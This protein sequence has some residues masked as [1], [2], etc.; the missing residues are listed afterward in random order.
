MPAVSE[1]EMNA[2]PQEMDMLKQKDIFLS[3]QIGALL[4]EPANDELES[5]VQ[6]MESELKAQRQQLVDAKIR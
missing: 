2:A 3:N 5:Q 4:K 1:D 6:Q